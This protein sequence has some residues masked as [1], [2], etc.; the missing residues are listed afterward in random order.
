MGHKVLQWCRLWDMLG[1]GPITER[2][3]ALAISAEDIAVDLERLTVPVE[4][5]SLFGGDGPVHVEVGSGKGTFLLNQA[6]ANR[7][8]N[9]LGIEWANKYYKYSVDRMRRWQVENVRLLRADARYFVER[10]LADRSVAVFHIYFPDPW[11]KKRHHKR[12]FFARANMLQVHRC[13]ETGGGLRAAT[14]HADYFEVMCEALLNEGHEERMF[15]Q[16]DFD[17]AAGA[18]AGEWVGTNFE[19]KYVQEGRAIYTLAVRKVN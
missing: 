19:R 1:L 14:D 16:I 18:E 11:P 6:R 7:Q 17:A 4:L 8:V 12:R 9:Y 3:V 10:C 5:A 15:E 2:C 13:L